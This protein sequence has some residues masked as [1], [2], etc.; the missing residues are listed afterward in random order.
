M[1]TSETAQWQFMET[2]TSLCAEY[3]RLMNLDPLNGS[4][5]SEKPLRSV[6]WRAIH[7]L[8]QVAPCHILIPKSDAKTRSANAWRSYLFVYPD[9]RDAIENDPYQRGDAQFCWREPIIDMMAGISADVAAIYRAKDMS[10]T[11]LSC[12]WA[13]HHHVYA[14]V[15]R[16]VKVKWFDEYTVRVRG[17]SGSGTRSTAGV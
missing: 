10:H 7:Q 15:P 5:Y 8:E 11:V 12:V 9:G 16:A 17:M 14:Q 2:N 6:D 4:E 1:S 3:E 13:R